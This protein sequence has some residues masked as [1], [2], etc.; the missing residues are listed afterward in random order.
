V[1][2][3]ASVIK[4]KLS[5]NTAAIVTLLVV[6]PPMDR[7]QFVSNEFALDYFF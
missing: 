5:K 4:N 7:E 6:S 3:S 1:P 2:A